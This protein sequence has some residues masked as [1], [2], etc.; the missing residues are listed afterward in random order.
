[1]TRHFFGLFVCCYKTQKLGNHFFV[2]A[3]VCVCVLLCFVDPI[4]GN[5]YGTGVVPRV[6]IPQTTCSA[7]ISTL[8]LKYIAGYT[9]PLL[10]LFERTH[11]YPVDNQGLLPWWLRCLGESNVRSAL[12]VKVLSDDKI[13]WVLWSQGLR[14]PPPPTTKPHLLFWEKSSK[15]KIRRRDT[16]VVRI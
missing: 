14:N 7:R 13:S 6:D 4:L 11:T 12:L 2:T 5:L 3:C 8:H 1:M 10:F 16:R 9:G 15:K